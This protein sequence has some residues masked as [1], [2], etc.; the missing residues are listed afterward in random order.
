M[1]NTETSQSTGF[2]LRVDNYTLDDILSL[3]ALDNNPS[4]TEI[5]NRLNQFI[6]IFET[7]NGDNRGNG[8]NQKSRQI[9][10]FFNEIGERLENELFTDVEVEGLEGQDSIHK[11]SRFQDMNTRELITCD[12][13]LGVDLGMGM[14]SSRDD[15]MINTEV[16][17]TEKHYN[18]EF[19]VFNQELVTDKCKL[20]D[21]TIFKYRFNESMNDVTEL[22]LSKIVLPMPYTISSYRQNNRFYIRDNSGGSVWTI[23]IEDAYLVYYTDIESMVAYLNGEYFNDDN[24]SNILGNIRLSAREKTSKRF[25]LRFDLSNNPLYST[26]SLSFLNGSDPEP[27]HPEY[28]LNQLL[29]FSD[30]EYLDIR[31]LDGS[32][33]FMTQS[34]LY[35]SLDDNQINYNQNLRTVGF[36]TLTNNILGSIYLNVADLAANDHILY[37]V[38]SLT[39]VTQN[40]R[41]YNGPVNLDTFTVRFYDVNGILQQIPSQGYNADCFYFIIKIT[42]EIASG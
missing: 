15:M 14:G 6:N 7:K 41:I 22:Y 40:G 34:K 38:F 2:D 29:G 12:N 24:S 4:M 1:V 3:L 42:R 21:R 36:H 25:G 26:F 17:K 32:A 16:S 10:N 19:S 35:F 30:V 20:V 23:E 33:I 9:I 28:A 27:I 39:E 31:R 37:N 8:E 11:N 13:S 5:N 18:Y